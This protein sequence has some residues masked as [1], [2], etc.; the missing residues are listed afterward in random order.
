MKQERITFSTCLKTPQLPLLDDD[1]DV[2]SNH[3]RLRI[4]GNR[5]KR[6]ALIGHFP[7]LGLLGTLSRLCYPG[8]ILVKFLIDLRLSSTW[9]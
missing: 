2:M 1:D 3:N 9:G 6:A 7:L 5:L 8:I 4:Q